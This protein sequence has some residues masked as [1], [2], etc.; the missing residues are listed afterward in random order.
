MLQRFGVSSHA[1][2][3]EYQHP[4]DRRIFRGSR[5]QSLQAWLR[6]HECALLKQGSDFLELFV[7]SQTGLR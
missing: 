2:G 5:K 3:E 4:V 6:L 1:R 7:R